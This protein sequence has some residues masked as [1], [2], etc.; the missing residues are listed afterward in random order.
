M[1]GLFYSQHRWLEATVSAATEQNLSFPGVDRDAFH[2]LGYV[3]V[4]QLF[5]VDEIERLRKLTLDTVAEY[6][7]EGR[8]FTDPDRE[9]ATR[10]VEGDLLSVPS[11]RHV[12]MDPRVLRVMRELLGGTPC[13]FGDSG[14]RIG[15][16]GARGWHRDNVNRRRWRGGPDWR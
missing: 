4:K 9:G 6:E 2:R 12:L 8:G 15:K 1:L 11:V 3:V 10:A 14:I 13:Y 7:S 16:N 5:G